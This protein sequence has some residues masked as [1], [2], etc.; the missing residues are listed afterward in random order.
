MSFY[1]LGMKLLKYED[2]QIKISEEAFL[3]KPIRE[4]HNA[5]KSK[6]KEFFLQQMSYM[7]FLVD[8]RSNYNYI[9]NE[10][11]KI[12]TIIEQEGLPKDFKPSKKLQEAIDIYK[13]LTITT[14][15]KL[16]NSMRIAINK[17]S[18]FLENVNLYATDDKGKRVDTIASITSAAD[19]IP[20]LT[21]KLIDTERLVNSEIDEISRIR[22]GE[23][24]A[25]A[26]EGGF[27]WKD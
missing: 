14:S 27:K 16:L 21:K 26:F 25:H 6:D 24:T 5:D 7:F 10:E 13:N 3:I 4:L 19:K 20:A 8:P 11:E 12:K 9:A 17:I 22:G 1:C 18:E 23:D 2:Y 15:Q